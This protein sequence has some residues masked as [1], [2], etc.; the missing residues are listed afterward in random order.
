MDNHNL[1]VIICNPLEDGPTIPNGRAVSCESC[2]RQLYASPSSL[3]L[4]EENPLFTFM[5]LSCGKKS[6]N[7]HTNGDGLVAVMVTDDQIKEISR[8]LGID[9]E[10]VKKLIE[11]E[12][13]DTFFC[14]NGDLN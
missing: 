6:A 3:K 2:G 13:G 11:K 12:L 4:A 10:D 5:C 9:E 14:N 1:G 7:E 8:Q